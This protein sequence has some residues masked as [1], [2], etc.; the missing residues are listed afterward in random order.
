MKKILYGS[1]ILI[2]LGAGLAANT[3]AELEEKTREPDGAAVE[4]GIEYS[5]A[6]AGSAVP[7]EPATAL[8]YVSSQEILHAADY[9]D[10]FAPDNY[11][12]APTIEIL[13]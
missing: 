2:M 1:L 8:A 12:L 4:P 13:Y 10:D 7:A 6:A 3:P 9:P 11:L 5:L